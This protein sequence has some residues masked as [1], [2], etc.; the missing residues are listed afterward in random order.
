[1]HIKRFSFERHFRSRVSMTRRGEEVIIPR[2]HARARINEPLPLA[3]I[4]STSIF[5]ERAIAVSRYRKL[6]GCAKKRFG[7]HCQGMIGIFRR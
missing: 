5:I 2:R 3:T 4:L 6:V 7:N 1:M